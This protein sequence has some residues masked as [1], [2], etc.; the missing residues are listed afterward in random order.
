MTEEEKAAHP[1]HKTTGGYLKELDNSGCALTWWKQLSEADKREIINIPNFD[2][3]IFKEI[4][5]IDVE[6]SD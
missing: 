2:R 4:T 6:M 1:E 5:G 3:D